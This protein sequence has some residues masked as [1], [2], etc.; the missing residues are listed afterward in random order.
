MPSFVPE[1]EES[2]DKTLART[3]RFERAS[4]EDKPGDIAIE[5][6]LTKR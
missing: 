3:D 5:Y 6:G 4:E 1:P 2:D